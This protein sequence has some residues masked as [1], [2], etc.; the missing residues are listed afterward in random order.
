MTTVNLS[1]FAGAGAQFF[2]NNGV[3][4]AGGLIYSYSAGTTTPQVTY[5]SN[6]GSIAQ[7]NPIV[8]DSSGRVTSGEIW[9]VSNLS[10]KFVVQNSS[11]VQIASY[12]NLAGIASSIDLSNVLAELANTSSNTQ[13][14]ALIGFVQSNSSGFLSGA[15]AS[16][17]NN[18]LQEFVSILDFIPVG[19]NTSTTD[20]SSYISAAI[21]ASNC[22]YIPEGVYL[23]NSTITIQNK[24]GFR[25]YG[26]NMNSELRWGGS[27]NG[28]MID[29][30]QSRFITF[31]NFYLN[32]NSIAG[33]NLMI[34]DPSGGSYVTTI[35]DYHKIRMGNNFPTSTLPA[36]SIGTSS[37]TQID[38]QTF[39]DCTIENATILF[40]MQSPVTLN[41]NFVS[42]EFEAYFATNTTTIGMNLI[43]GGNLSFTNCLWVGQATTAM[44]QRSIQFGL[45]GFINC[46][47]E[48]IGGSPF[49]YAVDD[50]AS[51]NKSPVNIINSTLGFNGTSGINWIDYRQRGP[52]LVQGCTINSSNAVYFNHAPPATGLFY[53]NGNNLINVSLTLGTYSIQGGFAPNGNFVAASTQG[54]MFGT[55]SPISGVL[56]TKRAGTSDATLQR[57]T[58]IASGGGSANVEQCVQTTI[59]IT[60][61]TNIASLE[62]ASFILVRG[63]DG[64]GNDFLDLLISG[65]SG[66]PTVITSKTIVGSPTARTY[67]I[68]SFNLQLAMASGTYTTNVMWFQL[69]AR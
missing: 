31:Q 67:S 8:L 14:D 23:I 32:G 62:N 11:G 35:G 65:N 6:S 17:V 30:S 16:T 18:K 41:I 15:Q 69:T 55:G 42:C 10:Y 26:A 45:L 63:S 57:I 20:C 54:N 53:N 40:Q 12:D 4:L 48:I 21:S 56:E 51:A 13:G 25:L 64:A 5:T 3:P 22:V 19:T 43:T 2:D 58:G 68:S 34:D 52:L 47:T 27:N 9:L 44:I 7:S 59:G 60:T 36:L 28:V 50:T 49:L 33:T 29:L 46:E 37:S 66:T 38:V 1:Q 24:S 61:A 39:Y